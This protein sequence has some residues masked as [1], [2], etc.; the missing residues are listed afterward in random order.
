MTLSITDWNLL[1]HTETRLLRIM[2]R[3]GYVL[4][5]D[6]L[7]VAT[8]YQVTI[9]LLNLPLV[10][11]RLHLNVTG[12]LEETSLPRSL[13]QLLLT[14]CCSTRLRMGFWGVLDTSLVSK[15][16]ALSETVTVVRVI[17]QRV[18]VHTEHIWGFHESACLSILATA[19]V[20]MATSMV[21]GRVTIL[22]LIYWNA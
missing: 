12:F 20:S 11:S 13:I 17:L 8:S 9:D 3:A 19:F 4:W 7:N 6:T 1:I 10:S 18:A 2:N 22:V 21:L 15:T 16:I 14:Y 5:P